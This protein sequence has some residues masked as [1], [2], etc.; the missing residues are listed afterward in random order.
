MAKKIAIGSDHG[1]Y[2]LKE[3]IKGVLAEKGYGVKD[4]GPVAED[5]CDYP[6]YGYEAAKLVSTGKSTRGIVI[7]KTGIGMSVVA[8]KLS[9]VRAGLCF[10]PAEAESARQHND[11][12]VLVLA[13]KKVSTRMAGKIVDVWLRT[14]ALRGRHARR[15]RQIKAIEAREFRKR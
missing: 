1:G 7:C 12:N 13:A 11:I 8:N 9:G 15:V 14:P 3:K 4:V 5:A 2:L 10:S 6:R